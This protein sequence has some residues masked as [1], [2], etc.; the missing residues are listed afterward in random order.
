MHLLLIETCTEQAMV[1]ITCNDVLAYQQLLPFGLQS[2]H[3]L[4]PTIQTGLN[5]LNIKPMDLSAIAVG[6]GP[7]SYTGM[8][9]GAITAKAIAYATQRPLIGICS[10]HCLTPQ[11]EGPFV[12]VLDA[13]MG[14]IYILA[15]TKHNGQVTYHSEP[16]VGQVEQFR[17]LLLNANMIVTPHTKSLLPKLTTAFPNA[18]WSWL[19]SHLSPERMAELARAKYSQGELSNDGSL[20]LLYLRKY[21]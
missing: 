3:L 9:V 13:K 8:R 20:E 15:G 21:P 19:E 18:T 5:S 6:T 1:A 2:G 16:S 14:G 4:A 11:Q 17:D 12:A 10:L 7:G